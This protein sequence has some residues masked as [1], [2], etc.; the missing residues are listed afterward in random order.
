MKH[1]Y[2]VG[3]L[4][5]NTATYRKDQGGTWYLVKAKNEQPVWT[6]SPDKTD[7]IIKTEVYP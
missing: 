2:R 7:E 3:N 4:A 1:L 6:K 5:Q